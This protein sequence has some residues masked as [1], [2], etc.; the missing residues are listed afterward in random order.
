MVSSSPAPTLMDPSHASVLGKVEGEKAVVQPKT[1][2]AGK[3]KKHSDSPKPS[4][5]SSKKNS[6]SSSRPSSED[7]KNLDDEIF[8]A[9]SYTVSQVFHCSGGTSYEAS[10]RIHHQPEAI[11]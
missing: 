1:T 8:K 11:L 2:P 7:L 10:S 9:G 6:S 4:P 3:K 5:R